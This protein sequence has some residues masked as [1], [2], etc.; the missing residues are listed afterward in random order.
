MTVPVINLQVPWIGKAAAEVVIE[1]VED[2][3][4]E[5]GVWHAMTNKQVSGSSLFMG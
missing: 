4:E 3:T 1:A 5:E 2:G